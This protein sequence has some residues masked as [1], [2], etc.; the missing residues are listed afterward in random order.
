MTLKNQKDLLNI[1]KIVGII[2]Q[3]PEEQIIST[4][5]FDEVIF[6]LEILLFLEKI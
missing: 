3:N 2:F 1:R 5:V 6:A 4:T